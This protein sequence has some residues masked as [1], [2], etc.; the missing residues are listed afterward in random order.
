M[1]NGFHTL[2]SQPFG[3]AISGGAM[4][5]GGRLPVATRRCGRAEL[6]HPP[7]GASHNFPYEYPDTVIGAV[8]RAPGYTLTRDTAR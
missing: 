4:L 3:G 6:I 7:A 8:R 5:V 2:L 1:L